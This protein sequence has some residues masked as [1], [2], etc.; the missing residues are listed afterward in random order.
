MN[1]V[2]EI[3]MEYRAVT[4]EDSEK[5]LTHWKY[6]K[7]VKKNGK[8]RYYYDKR[9][10]MYDV[11]SRDYDTKMKQ[12]AKSK[13]WQDIVS[14]NDPEYVKTLED[15]SKKYLID[16][17]LVKKKHPELDVISDLGAGRKVSLNE[18]NV[19]TFIAGAK[20]YIKSAQQMIGVVSTALTEKFK[21]QQG[22]YDKQINSSTKQV[23]DTINKGANFVSLLFQSYT[24]Y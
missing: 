3:R 20:D 19:G 12:I 6:I 16:D 22:S 14:R 1:K 13:E 5:D 15:G 23:N 10:N 21:L 8:W 18:M 7:R 17:Y 9:K 2:G 24:R 11:S 4:K